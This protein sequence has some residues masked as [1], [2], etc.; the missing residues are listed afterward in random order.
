[1]SGTATFPR[2]SP[3]TPGETAV[4]T[5]L[6]IKPWPDPLIDTIGHDPRSLY[7]ETFWLPTLG[8]TVL[9]LMRHLATASTG[10]RPASTSPSPTRASRRARRARRREL[11]DHAY[12]HAARAV[13][14]RLRG[15]VHPDRRGATQPAAG[16]PPPCPPAPGRRGRSRTWMGRGRARGG[17]TGRP[18]AGPPRGAR[19]ARAGRRPRPRRARSCSRRASTPPSPP[20]RRARGVGPAHRGR[21]KPGSRQPPPPDP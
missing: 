5:T 7:V 10:R 19:T 17:T 13:R 8:P 11:A 16:E 4:P 21:A 12:P 9:L 3:R 20:R 14:P 18:A 6:T 2:M 1:M 15:S